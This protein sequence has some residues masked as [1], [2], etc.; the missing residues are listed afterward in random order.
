VAGEQKKDWELKSAQDVAEA[1]DWLRR[2]MKGNG[3]VLVAIGTNSVAYCKDIALRPN[4]AVELIE[5]NLQTIRAGLG[6][7][8]ARKE[9]RGSLRRGDL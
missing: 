7:A 2:R 1:L 4:D 9:T 6:Q 8:E 3:L 5:S